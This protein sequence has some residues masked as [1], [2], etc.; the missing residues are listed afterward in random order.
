MTKGT[1]QEEVKDTSRKEKRVI[2]V[3]GDGLG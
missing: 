3:C 1:L 2:T